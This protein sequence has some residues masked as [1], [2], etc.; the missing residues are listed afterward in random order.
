MPEPRRN[1]YSSQISFAQG[2][3]SAAPG[4]VT[5]IADALEARS[6]HSFSGSPAIC[7]AIKYPV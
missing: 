1:P 4:R 3:E 5:L 6:M 2:I 7:P